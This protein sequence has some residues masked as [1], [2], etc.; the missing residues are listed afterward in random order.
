M[1]KREYEAQNMNRKDIL[2]KNISNFKIK[3]EIN[4]F[5]NLNFEM[6]QSKE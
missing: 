3:K 1:R 4:K 6:K 5:K 2:C